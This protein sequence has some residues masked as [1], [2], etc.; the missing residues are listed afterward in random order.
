MDFITN[1]PM[2]RLQHNV[3]MI[4]VDKLTKETHFIIVK[5]THKATEIADIYMKEVARLH[6]IPKVIVSNMHSKFTNYFLKGW[7]KDFGTYVNVSTS[8]HPQTNGQTK[9]VNQVIEDMLIMYVMDQPT[10]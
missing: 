10:K 2:T 4:V 6:G 1:L 7:F 5:N 3:I 9:R 8:H